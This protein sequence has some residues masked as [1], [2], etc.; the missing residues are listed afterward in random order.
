[1]KNFP[2]ETYF[3]ASIRGEKGLDATEEDIKGNIEKASKM[4]EKVQSLFGQLLNIYVPHDHDQVVGL[5]Y[6]V[7][8]VA[9]KEVLD[10]DVA[11]L[12]N[13]KLL[14]SWCP[15]DVISRGMAIEIAAAKEFQIPIISFK[16]VC[17]SFVFSMFEI[18]K[19]II[20]SLDE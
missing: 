9:E 4:A 6:K 8:V 17:H 13:K 10:A 15:R 12:K 11:I 19:Q 18:I 5:L 1:M 14:L 2:I 20:R 16:E 7:G 3:S